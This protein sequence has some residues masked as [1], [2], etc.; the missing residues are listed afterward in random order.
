MLS[1]QVGRTHFHN[2]YMINYSILLIGLFFSVMYCACNKSENPVAAEVKKTIVSE[3]GQLHVE[4]IKLL[5]RQG[6][7]A[8]LRGMSLFWSQ[9]IGKYYNEQCI[10]WLRDD[11][12]CTVVRAAV[13]VDYGGYLDNPAAEMQKAFNVIDACIKYGIYVIVDWHDHEAELHAD[14]A[15]TFFRT[16][17]NKYGTM[18][19]VIYEIY[20]EP[21]Q[22]SWSDVVKPYAEEVIAEI[23]KIDPDNLIIVGSP[24]W[25]QD[26]DIAALDPITDT[27]VA[28]SLHFYTGTHRQSLR[29]KAITAMD[30]GLP[31]FVNE[32]GLSEANGDGNI[33]YKETQIW[34]DF[35]DQ[36]QL[37]WCTWSI[38]DKEETSAALKPG[39]AAEGNWQNLDLSESGLFI[40]EAIRERNAE[41]LNQLH[42]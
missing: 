24:N 37:S 5:D 34:M 16:I 11:W 9:W 33:D 18:A 29:D 21:L 30:K 1:D 35:L 13:A 42:E 3:M 41:I 14:Q 36:Y 17:A 15:K 19:N 6:Q 26:V 10:K 22:V 28:Y 8:V 31:L 25:S 40:R 27:N 32:W 38:S 7:V 39:A 4:G 23:R 2:T 20:N 12:N